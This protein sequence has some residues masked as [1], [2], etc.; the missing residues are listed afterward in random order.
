MT[1]QLAT[2]LKVLSCKTSPIMAKVKNPLRRKKSLQG[3][4]NLADHQLLEVWQK[5]IQNYCFDSDKLLF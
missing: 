1:R 5:K 2:A 3:T 4:L